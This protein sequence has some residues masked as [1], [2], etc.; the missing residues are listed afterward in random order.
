MCD[1]V[2]INKHLQKNGRFY[3]LGFKGIH[4]VRFLQ[5]KTIKWLYI[6]DNSNK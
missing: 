1:K 3:L 5:S 6:V 2:I 4:L